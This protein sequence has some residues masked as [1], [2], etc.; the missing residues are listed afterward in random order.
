MEGI[1]LDKPILYKHSS[2]RFFDKNEHRVEGFCRDDVFLLVYDGILRFSEDGEEHEV[3][4]GEYYIQK[5]N[6]FQAGKRVSDSPKYLYVHFLAEWADSPRALP[7]TGKFSYERMKET[8]QKLDKV[9]RGD[10]TYTEKTR[11]FFELLSE[12]YR[13]HKNTGIA[14]QIAEFIS[15]NIICIKSLDDICNEFNYSRNHIIN[16]FKKEYGMTPFEYINETKIKRAMYL[17]EVTSDSVG[18]IAE[19]SGFESYSHFYRLFLR[20]NGVSPCQWRKQIHLR[21]V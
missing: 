16:L 8:I 19:E 6:T 20:R 7:K 18:D 10:Y 4:A 15:N 5:A 21:P 3:R 17:L 11:Y 14:G 9:S 2:L 13:R 12:L 1:N